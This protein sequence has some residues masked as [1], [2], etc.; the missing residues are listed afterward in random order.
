MY[1]EVA[2][3]SVRHSHNSFYSVF[4]SQI[5]EAAAAALTGITPPYRTWSE[6]MSILH[7]IRPSIPENEVRASLFMRDYQEIC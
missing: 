6:A 7:H 2:A 5:R 3:V 1:A 4:T